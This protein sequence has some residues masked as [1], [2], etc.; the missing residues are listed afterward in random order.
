[1]SDNED[2]C[3]EAPVFWLDA[4]SIWVKPMLC[5]HTHADEMIFYGLLP[6]VS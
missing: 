3:Q 4:P 2:E 1:M 5:C 6:P